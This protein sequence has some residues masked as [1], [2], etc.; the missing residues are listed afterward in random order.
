MELKP[1]WQRCASFAP[2]SGG[3]SAAIQRIQANR[4][5]PQRRQPYHSPPVPHLRDHEAEQ[6]R[7]LVV[8]KLAIVREAV[9]AR[10][11]CEPGF[12][13]GRAA[14]LAEARGMLEGVDIAIVDLR[15][16][17]GNGADLI[18]ELHAV[19]PQAKAVVHTSSIDPE[20]AHQALERGAAAVLNKLA[21]L[22]DVI[23]TVRRLQRPAQS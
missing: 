10:L 7:L 1:T 9:A 19:N 17:D 20:D 8:Q 15:L 5:H 16:P 18:Q 4:S 3:F 21:G 11:D 12:T 14:S 23:A 2:D 22:D 13:V 6:V